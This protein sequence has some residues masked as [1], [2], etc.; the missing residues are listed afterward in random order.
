MSLV[1]AWFHCKPPY[2]TNITL[3]TEI[4]SASTTSSIKIRKCS[5]WIGATISTKRQL[6]TPDRL[7]HKK[8]KMN[9]LNRIMARYTI[10]WLLQS[11]SQSLFHLVSHAC[12]NWIWKVGS[13]VSVKNLEKLT[14]NRNK[15][16]WSQCQYK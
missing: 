5:Y 7:Q 8:D 4:N 3:S 9:S 6:F 2:P 10:Q 16:I 13:K 15:Q 1:I 12:L 14:K 11:V